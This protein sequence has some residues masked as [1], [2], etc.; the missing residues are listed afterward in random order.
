MEELLKYKLIGIGEFSHGIQESWVFRFKLLKYAMKNTNNKIKIFNEMSAWQADNI[1]ND[2]I[3][4]RKLNKQIKYN[5]I[6]KENPVEG[7]DD[8]TP[9]GKLWQYMGHSTESKIFLKIIKYIRENKNRINIIGIDN[10]KLDR[11]YNMYKNIIN[12]YNSKN[13]N[14]LW[15]HNHHIDNMKYSLDN[16]L[17]IKNKNHKWFCGH[18]LKKYFKNDYCIILSQAYEGENRFNSYCI[19]NHCE[20]RIWAL[21]YIYTKFKYNELK[22]YVDKSKKYQLLKTFDNKLISFSNS[23]YK[24][25]K[26]GVQSFNISKTWDYILFWNKVNKLEPI[27]NY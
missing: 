8:K 4:C 13:I 7:G 24:G 15:A 23:Y 20:K 11:D 2:T 18:Y 21:K 19:D 10:D 5:I 27:Y 25:N 26:Y 16:L 17:Y 6:K 12:N 9:W 3:Y 22:K 1:M 14:F